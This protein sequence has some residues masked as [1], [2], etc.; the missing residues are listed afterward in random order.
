MRLNEL[1]PHL[2]TASLL[3]TGDCNQNN[4]N[5]KLPLGCRD[6]FNQIV[7]QSRLVPYLRETS[8]EIILEHPLVLNFYHDWY[9][10][11]DKEF[12]QTLDPKKLSLLSILL[13]I[14]L[15]GVREKDLIVVPTNVT[16]CSI[17]Q[18]CIEQHISTPV[19]VKSGKIRF[20]Q[21]AE[22]YSQWKAGI[23]II[24]IAQFVHLLTSTELRKIR[25]QKGLR[26]EDETYSPFTFTHSTRL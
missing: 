13:S 14:N 7:E 16:N 2:I 21:V 19:V 8:N 18:Y 5:F 24:H 12:A 20:S 23:E 10:G 6:Y 17:L 9:Q 3:S 26:E 1:V 4:L 22:L 15:Y 25:L 11:E